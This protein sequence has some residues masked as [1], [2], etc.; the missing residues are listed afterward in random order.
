MARQTSLA[1]YFRSFI[2]TTTSLP[3]N[4]TDFSS[5]MPCN[6]SKEAMYSTETMAPTEAMNSTEMMASKEAMNLTEMMASKEA[7]NS[8]EIETNSLEENSTHVTYNRESR[9]SMMDSDSD[10]IPAES[11]ISLSDIKFPT[12][13]WPSFGNVPTLLTPCFGTFTLTAGSCR[14]NDSCW[15]VGGFV[16]GGCLLAEQYCCIP[17]VTCDGIVDRN[18]TVFTSP[19]YPNATSKTSVCRV[20]V[21][22]LNFDIR[23]LRLDFFTFRLAQPSNTGCTSDTLDIEG[24]LLHSKVPRLCG[25]ND[26]SH[27]YVPVD[28]TS[29]ELSIVISMS[30]DDIPRSWAIR[31]LQLDS[32]S[33]LPPSNCL[34]YYTD[35]T[36]S[37]ESFNNNN[38]V[39]HGVNYAICIGLNEGFCGATYT[40]VIFNLPGTNGRN[41]DKSDFIQLPPTSTKGEPLCG[42]RHF[43]SWVTTRNEPQ[44]IFVESNGRIHGTGFK[45][46]YQQNICEF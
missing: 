39:I 24:S 41:C 38:S 45:F 16:D 1:E 18:G 32:K 13:N 33:D 23:Q 28:Q 10:L 30:G 20:K 29:N 9:A 21:N 5:I 22:K 36:G 25:N 42:N 17:A 43:D 26:G 4:S 12:F 14:N 46:N 11:S 2:P 7:M 37:I 31:V 34:Q 6:K 44:V 19:G 3:M 40:P 15:S 35:N 27:I 8:K